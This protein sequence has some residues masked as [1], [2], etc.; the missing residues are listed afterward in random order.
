[1]II[2]LDIQSAVLR[3]V[4]EQLR[5]DVAKV[6]WKGSDVRSDGLSRT[7]D[8]VLHIVPIPQSKQPLAVLA[9]TGLGNEIAAFIGEDTPP[10]IRT[11]LHHRSEEHT[12]EL[13]SPMY[14]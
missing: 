7:I 14:L 2:Y 4:V 1:M 3:S 5:N 13:Q 6:F 12:S 10:A 8:C 11:H 9:V